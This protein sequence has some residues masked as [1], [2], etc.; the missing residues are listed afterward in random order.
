MDNNCLKTH[1]ANNNVCGKHLYTILMKDIFKN[2]KSLETC[3]VYF[4]PLLLLLGQTSISRKVY[5]AITCTLLQH[6]RGI[7]CTSLIQQLSCE[8]GWLRIYQTT[9][10][11]FP[12]ISVNNNKKMNYAPSIMLSFTQ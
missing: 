8:T 6:F 10:C 3:E 1:Q 2:D 9:L 4:L 12:Q 5:D 7:S 11:H